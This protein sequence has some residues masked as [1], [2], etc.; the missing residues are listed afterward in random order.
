MPLSMMHI[1]RWRVYVCTQTVL[2]PRLPGQ[3]S[4]AH[5]LPRR[6]AIKTLARLAIFRCRNILMALATT[7]PHQRGAARIRTWSQSRPGHQPDP[8]RL[9]YPPPTNRTQRSTRTHI[10][11]ITRAARI[12]PADQVL[13]AQWPSGLSD[14]ARM[15]IQHH[16]QPIAIHL[17]N[18][19][20]CP[21]RQVANI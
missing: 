20:L 16:S 8:P 15:D 5:P 13:N 6:A 7:R 2:A 18:L 3:L 1:R 11:A 4:H 14:I 17:D 12:I 9:K 19:Q 10:S 21:C